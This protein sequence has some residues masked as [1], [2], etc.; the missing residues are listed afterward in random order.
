MTHA[1]VVPFLTEPMR[2]RPEPAAEPSAAGR[3]N[4]MKPRSDSVL[5]RWK[6]SFM[7]RGPS[8]R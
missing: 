1:P 8:R 3:R 2:A 5:T 6:R 7:P 4:D